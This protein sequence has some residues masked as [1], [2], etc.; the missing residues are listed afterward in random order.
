MKIQVELKT[1]T[2]FN[3]G[4]SDS[5]IVNTKALTDNDGFVYFHSKTLKGQ[6]KDRAFWLYDRYDQ[7]CD[8]QEQAKKM[9]NA[10]AYLFGIEQEELMSRYPDKTKYNEFTKKLDDSF[11]KE[12]LY[13]EG[14][15]KIGNLE[16]D[17]EFKEIFKS[18]RKN[19]EDYINFSKDALIKAQ[20]NIRTNIV[21][22]ENGVTQDKFLGKYHT[23]R[24]GFKFE[25]TLNYIPENDEKAESFKSE[26]EMIV[27]S[28][29][30]IGSSINR[31]RG[32]V[33]SKLLSKSEK[34]NIKEGS[35]L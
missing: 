29:D 15:L 21:I 25:S 27:K 32:K 35:N 11:Q 19:D 4:E 20:T 9:A 33:V 17:K 10:I 14:H 16:F 7:S 13:C 30:R 22:G 34:T 18:L 6:L 3:S 2:I 26:L 1:E 24:S 23:I 12:P 8:G 5:N 31:G 28:L